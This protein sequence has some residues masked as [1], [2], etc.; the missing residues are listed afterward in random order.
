MYTYRNQQA[1]G[2]RKMDIDQTNK[3]LIQSFQCRWNKEWR[4]NQGGISRDRNQWTQRITESYN[5]R[6]EQNRHVFG[7]QLIGQVQSRSQLEEWNN[8]VY[9]M[10]RKLQNETSGYQ[11]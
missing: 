6:F 5:N 4:S 2:Q 9:E 3:L 11:V 7:L 8:K 10:S 1:T